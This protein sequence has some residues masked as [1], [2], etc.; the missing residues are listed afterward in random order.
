M[1]GP[2][3]VFWANLAPFSPQHTR[4]ELPTEKL[5]PAASGL[6]VAE[7]ADGMNAYL[8]AGLADH[9]ARPDWDPERMSRGGESLMALQVRR[10]H[11]HCH[12]M[13]T[14]SPP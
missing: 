1:H 7:W 11:H 9:A 12:A 6:A 4:F 10:S 14:S 13:I 5:P 8:A 3:R 2:T